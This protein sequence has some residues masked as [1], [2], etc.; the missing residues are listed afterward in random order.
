MKTVHI[1]TKCRTCKEDMDKI[2][3]EK[4]AVLEKAL[5]LACAKLLSIY[6]SN[7]CGETSNCEKIVCEY[8]TCSSPD[9]FK[10]KAK[11]ELKSE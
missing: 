8:Q 5:K 9:Y 7:Y 3:L 6:C 4:I 1:N 2:L 11:E 10:T